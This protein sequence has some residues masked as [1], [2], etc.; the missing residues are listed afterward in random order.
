MY[1]KANE[2]SNFEVGFATWKP[3]TECLQRQSIT[4]IPWLEKRC[5][6]F[7]EWQAEWFYCNS[8]AKHFN[9]NPRF[10][11]VPYQFTFLGCSLCAVSSY[12]NNYCSNKVVARKSNCLN[13][14]YLKTVGILKTVDV[15]I[16]NWH[17]DIHEECFN[18][19]KNV[20]LTKTWSICHLIW[21]ETSWIALEE[22]SP[23]RLNQ[24]LARQ[25]QNQCL[26]KF[27]LQSKKL[28]MTRAGIEPTTLRCDLRF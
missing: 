15:G 8:L 18:F 24:L 12:T 28:W 27:P 2:T 13:A 20:L 26:S 4:S 19:L 9:C 16:N 23:L 11:H 6:S 14:Y 25:F 21:M 7:G 10:F 22:Q 17:F 3:G 1:I 5:Y